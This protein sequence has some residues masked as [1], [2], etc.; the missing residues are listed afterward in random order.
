MQ[1]QMHYHVSCLPTFRLLQQLL[2]LLLWLV[3]SKR[4]L[5]NKLPLHH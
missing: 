2:T 1:Q 5:P 4:I 3:L